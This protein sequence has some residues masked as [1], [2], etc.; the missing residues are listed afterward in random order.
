MNSFL[1]D[2]EYLAT[3]NSLPFTGNWVNTALSKN[4]LIVA[5]VSGSTATLN[6]EGK[7]LIN[8][9]SLPNAYTFYTA[10]GVTGYMS[11]AFL[12]SPISSI[13]ISSPT[14][15]GKVWAYITYQN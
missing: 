6:L 8:E 9:S 2:T 5:Y 4:A 10:T 12:D 14:N 1:I 3:G 11:P 15:S 13:R 7:S